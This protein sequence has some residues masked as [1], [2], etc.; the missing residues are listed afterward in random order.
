MRHRPTTHDAGGRRTTA[1][2]SAAVGLVTVAATFGLAPAASAATVVEADLP[3][4]V[5]WDTVQIPTV[6]GVRYVD[7]GNRALT[8]TVD[9]PGVNQ[10]GFREI[11]IKAVAE[12]GYTLDPA[13]A[14]W[15]YTEGGRLVSRFDT[16]KDDELIDVSA[17]G[18]NYTFTNVQ[19]YAVEYSLFAGASEVAGVLRSGATVRATATHPYVY[20]AAQHPDDLSASAGT[21]FDTFEC[22]VGQ[23][24]AGS[25]VTV[26][27]C[28]ITFERAR[29]ASVDIWE[30]FYRDAEGNASLEGVT[31]SRAPVEGDWATP[32]TFDFS[33]VGQQGLPVFWGEQTVVAGQAEPDDYIGSRTIC[34]GA[35][36]AAPA[37]PYTSVDGNKITVAWNP[38][39]ATGSSPV[40]G[41]VVKSTWNGT[42][43]YRAVPASQTRLPL[44]KQP[45]GVTTFV[46][47]AT[48]AA[49]NSAP[50]PA[51]TAT[52]ATVPS[53]PALPGAVVKGRNIT[54]S[55]TPP[56]SNGGAAITG[57]VVQVNN[58]YVAV[59]ATARTLTFRNLAA[60]NHYIRVYATNAR[61]NSA[62]SAVRKVTLR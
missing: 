18:C 9:L 38:V 47:Y 33:G 52:V 16:L 29:G 59:P 44:Q 25:K 11:T 21:S 7:G 26:N 40:T 62:G 55:W 35:V 36:P 6:P 31:A 45:A 19:P 24:R 58:R 32:V 30:M 34:N 14:G 2:V 53:A 61:G 27:D 48:N 60:G 46:I 8:G 15:E 20:L 41:Y 22:A 5:D 57:Y 43:T 56:T 3:T 10:F 1:L 17:E 23:G 49:G 4:Y 50:S 51:R 39:T 13:S 37:R 28:R 42:S 54:V 12:S